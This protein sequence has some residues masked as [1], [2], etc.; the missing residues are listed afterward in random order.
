MKFSFLIPAGVFL[1]S[2]FHGL[3]A[4]VPGHVEGWGNNVYGQASPPAGLDGVIAI[5]A[6]ARHSLA[7]RTNGT[8]VAWGDNSDGESAVPPGLSNVVAIAACLHSVAVKGDGTVVL[9]GSNRPE[10]MT[11]PADATGIVAI[12]TSGS[13]GNGDDYTLALRRDGM[14]RG[15]GIGFYGQANVP[16]DLTGVAAITA[17]TAYALALKKDGS[18]AGWGN[19]STAL[20]P[21]AGLSGVL[22]VRAG[23]YA[24]LAV[25]SDGTIVAWADVGSSVIN[26][27]PAGL[28]GIEDAQLGLTHAAALRSDGTVIAWG[29]INDGQRPLQIT[30]P[31]A[32]NGVS[33]I[34]AGFNH[35]LYLTARPVLTEIVPP[36]HPHIG[37]TV[38]F[39]ANASGADSYQW[40]K[41]GVELPG[42]TNRSFTISNMQPADVGTYSIVARNQYGSAS[43]EAPRFSPPIITSQPQSLTRIRGETASFSVL[44]SGLGPFQYQWMKN[45]LEIADATSSTLTATNLRSGDAG[46]YSVKV[47][48]G[49]HASIQSATATLT[50]TDPTAQSTSFLPEADASIFS[51]GLDPKG[52]SDIIAGTRSDGTLDR[53]LLR[54]DLSSLPPGVELTSVRLRLTVVKVPPEPFSSSFSLFR[55]LKAW[56]DDAN[57][58]NAAASVPWAAIGAL[59]GLDYTT[60]ISGKQFVAG[61]GTY[62]FGPSAQLLAD[63]QSWIAHPEENHGWLLKSESESSARSA[64]H[65][66]PSESANPPQLLIDYTIP[67]IAPV[68][69]DI[70]TA[71]G[72]L[73]FEIDGAAGW[74]YRIEYRPFLEKSGWATFTNAP[75]GAALTPVVIRVPDFGESGF[76]RALVE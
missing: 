56:G 70:S 76:F 1:C 44:Q 10:I 3:A 18:I 17:G 35:D 6:G 61:L 29:I 66:G 26:D 75:A 46:S 30:V 28:S 14:V 22:A 24:S 11:I 74:I 71:N 4:V 68:L 57:W 19:G 9:W 23:Q 38:T 64:R 59:G 27:M 51:N 52:T 25:K 36:M 54:F 73:R 65:F 40:S 55:M 62:E 31:P 60:N 69:K 72:T 12:A 45:G 8:V 41:N 5:A 34:A 33:A 20:T 39:I 50:V 49:A 13:F 43:A 37:G 48:D 16:S 67:P 58:T 47:T 32:I 63:V 42:E 7:L 21:P 53:G 15:W 2:F